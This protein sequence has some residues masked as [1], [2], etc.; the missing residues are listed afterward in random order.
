MKLAASLLLLAM[1][2]SGQEHHSVQKRQTTVIQ[3][4]IP[5]FNGV[6][7]TIA[8]IDLST[9]AILIVAFLVLDIVGTIIF[10][11]VVGS[12]KRSHQDGWFSSWGM[13]DISG[14]MS[15]IYNRYLVLIPPLLLYRTFII[16][17][18]CPL[19]ACVVCLCLS[20]LQLLTIELHLCMKNVKLT[21]VL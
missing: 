19:K 11:S 9:V 20:I 10:A 21:K 4:L 17:W 2:V 13:S 14:Y 6:S 3:D 18:P 7:R 1:V 8:G 15:N 12:G 5:G 16:T